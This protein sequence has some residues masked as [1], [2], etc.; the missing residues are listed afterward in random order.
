MLQAESE[1]VMQLWVSAVQRSITTAYSENKR[2]SGSFVSVP[3][4]L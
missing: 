1:R 2:D 4:R 3:M